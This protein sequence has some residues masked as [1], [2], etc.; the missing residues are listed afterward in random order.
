MQGL[1]GVLAALLLWLGSST[2][3]AVQGSTHERVVAARAAFVAELETYLSW[4]QEKSLFNERRK[5]CE[6]MVELQPEHAEARK[7]LGHTREKG[8]GWKVPEKPKAFR[9]F[10]KQALEEAPARWRATT[11]SFVGALT[12]IVASGGLEADER[13][14]VAREALRFDPDDARLHELLGEVARDKGWVLP[15][16]VSAKARRAV[17][18]DVV[19]SALEGAP[20]AEPVPLDE[21]ERKIPLK[22]E[23]VAGPRLR[24]AGTT[25]LEEL[26]LAAQAVHAI[27]YLAQQVFYTR[28]AL[29]DN[30]TVFLLADPVQREPFLKSHPAVPPEQQAY[31]AK[32]ECG[33]IQGT[34]DFAFWTGDTQRRIDGTVRLVLGYWLSGAYRIRSDMGW[35]Y[36]GF[37]LY[38]TR[39]LVQTR[40]TWLAQPSKVLTQ[41]QDMAL[42]QKLIDPATNWMDET[43]RLWMEG[44][45]PKLP[46]LFAKGA[47]DLTTEDVLASYALATYLLE[48]RAEVVAPMLERLGNGFAR[49]QAFQ[50]AVNMDLERFQRHF[51]RWLEERK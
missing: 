42:R 46:E 13:E 34:N 48:A 29:P 19:T 10:D 15:E 33:G 2:S 20:A 9:D 1:A 38:L 26:R 45:A 14:T 21:R 36:E 11:A 32:L 44:R 49:T 37:G 16:K 22:L 3:G 51:R 4:C 39:S 40:M 50:E 43:L 7:L 23:A 41:A 8:G 30:T 12:E 47:S 24:V 25:G 31:F 35:V 6:L 17:L 27:E 5:V 18:R 28:H